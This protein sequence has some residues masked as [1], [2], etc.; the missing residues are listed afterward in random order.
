M[1]S[2]NIEAQI[3]N[4]ISLLRRW[5]TARLGGIAHEKRVASLAAALVRATAPLHTLSTQEMRTLR[6]G[7]LV[8]DVG[9]S[10]SD[11]NHPLIGA[12]MILR[13]RSLPLKNR[14][15]RAL[16]FLARHHRGTVPIIHEDRILRPH[17]DA[18]ALRL[19]LAFLRAADGLDSRSL[20]SPRV[21]FR[22][23]G[24]VLKINCWLASD[25]PKARR[26]FSRRKKFR[27]LEEMLGCKVQ[28]AIRSTSLT[29]RLRLA[30]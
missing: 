26:V 4:K 10:V 25:S 19:V 3:A 21:K 9:R 12:R 18:P 6:W 28:V 14:Q 29:R 1:R 16:A 5:V 22:L 2:A 23:Q 7:A 27:L 8:H 24:R 30:A 15:R 11:K 13:D 20:P 17:D